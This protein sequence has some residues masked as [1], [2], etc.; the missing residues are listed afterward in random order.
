MPFKKLC[1]KKNK[2]YT[3]YLLRV[4]GKVGRRTFNQSDLFAILIWSLLS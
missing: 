2:E 4:A 1:N 3:Q